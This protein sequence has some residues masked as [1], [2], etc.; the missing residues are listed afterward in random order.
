[1]GGA[2][3][4]ACGAVPPS[5]REQPAGA[6]PQKEKVQLRFI[7]PGTSWKE[8]L[9]STLPA[10]HQQNPHIQVDWVSGKW[11]F[12]D[13]VVTHAVGGDLEDVV[14]YWFGEQAPQVWFSSGFIV[15]LDGYVKT[16]KLNPKDWYRGQWEMQ[17]LDGKQFGVPA[18]GQVHGITLYYNKNVF[19]EV[20]VKHPTPDWTLDDLVAAAEQL[21]VVEG[22]E[23]KRWGADAVNQ[24]YHEILSAYA[25]NF[26]AEMFS[27]DQKRFTWGQ[28][29]EFLRFLE[30]YTGVM[31]RRTGVVYSQG[32]DPGGQG[33][34][35]YT[36]LLKGKVAM[37]FKGWLGAT[38]GMA[39]FLRDN[40]GVSYGATLTPKGPTGRRGGFQT[41]GGLFISRFSKHPDE[42]FKVVEFLAGRE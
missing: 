1:M 16:A 40:P 8:A 38:G 36:G 21:K 29:P 19:D 30:W 6:A 23:V 11:P 22:R 12:I 15:P 7:M 32:G 17:F 25:R 42:A 24:L 10:W 20:G 9:E 2:T 26:N 37:I 5:A 28:G 27:P 18:A 4:A 31:Q 33:T 34:E 41:S 13:T 35:G 14:Y 3:A 39:K